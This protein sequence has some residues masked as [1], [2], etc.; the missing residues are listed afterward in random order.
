MTNTEVEK[1]VQL[2]VRVLPAF[3]DNTVL[4]L[5]GGTAINLFL[6]DA[7]RLSVDLD[8]AY[9]RLDDRSTALANIGAVLVNAQKR[10]QQQGLRVQGLAT[11]QGNPHFDKL[12]IQDAGVQVGIEVN[13][14]I[15]G[16]V[17][18]A[19]RQRIRAEIEGRFGFAES[20]L[21]SPAEIYAGKMVAALDR[22]KPHDLFDIKLMLDQGLLGNITM[23]AFLVY[24][25]A[26]SR[27]IIELLD[28]SLRNISQ[29]YRQNFITMTNIPVTLAALEAARLELI[30][31]IRR[32]LTSHQREFLV[33]LQRREPLW[34][35]LAI[36]N[37]EQYPAIRRKL[38]NLAKMDAKKAQVMSMRLKALLMV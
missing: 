21:L 19:V 16:T 24:L 2:L 26:S 20:N 37:I 10:L 33:S 4:A 30:Q 13:T 34:N 12:N 38:D 15:R 27:P 8:F 7:P 35:L 6:Q 32:D 11:L 14:I 36:D 18:P 28:P 1:Q 25:I 23:Q 9:T 29:E 17:Y 31:T 5:K 3:G 22:Q